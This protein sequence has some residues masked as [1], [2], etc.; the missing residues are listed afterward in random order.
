MVR[1]PYYNVLAH[2]AREQLEVI[3]SLEHTLGLHVDLGVPRDWEPTALRERID[4]EWSVLHEATRPLPLS[5]RVSFHCPPAALIWRD[6]EGYESA[7]AARWEGQYRSDSYG[8]FRYG[9]PEDAEERP[10][11]INLHPEHWCGV[12]HQGHEEF[13][14]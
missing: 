9:D 7:Y 10:L 14:R 3:H 11:Q 6:L 12:P 8:L 4:Y 1:S 2:E 13:W 5:R